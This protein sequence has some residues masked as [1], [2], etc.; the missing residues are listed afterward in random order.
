MRII[1]D[2]KIFWS[3]KYGGISRYFINIFKNL[4]G[5]KKIDF[6]IIAPFYQNIY[7]NYEIENKKIF[8]IYLKKKIPKTSFLYEKFNNFFLQMLHINLNQT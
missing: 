1:Y 2:H 7:L 5:N 4:K 8:G 3:Q 6:K